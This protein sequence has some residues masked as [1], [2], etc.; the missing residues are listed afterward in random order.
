M[1]VGSKGGAGG[2]AGGCGAEGGA[3]DDEQMY[4]SPMHR[5]TAIESRSIVI[6]LAVV[7]S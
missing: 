4:N 1:G 2:M 6:M 3:S 7:T 5:F